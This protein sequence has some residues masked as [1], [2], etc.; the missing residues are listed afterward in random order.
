MKSIRG[1]LALILVFVFLI[2]G[3][4]VQR[5][6]IAPLTWLFPSRRIAILGRWEH[7]MKGLVMSPIVYVGG[8]RFS[9]PPAIP[10]G[11]DVLIIA[12]HQSVFDIPLVIGCL[13]KNTYPRFVTRKRYADWI[14]L[15]SHLIRLYQYPSVDPRANTQAMK[16][17]LAVLRSAARDGDTPLCLFP[18]GTRSKNGEIG[19]FRPK[20]MRII[21]KQRPWKVYAVVCDG[22]WKTAK[23][24]D[25]LRGMKSVRGRVELAGVFDWSDPT[26]DVDAFAEEVRQKMIDHLMEMRQTAPV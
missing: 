17:S 6:I 19:E 13:P 11:E 7:F 22:M 15:V 25:F 23:L 1:S 2:L 26:Q 24:R 14:P 9:D 8:A 10:G 4:P 16:E 5:F 12:N 20:G 21:L 3:D 18:E